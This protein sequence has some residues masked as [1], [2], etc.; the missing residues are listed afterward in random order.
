MGLNVTVN[1]VLNGNLVN[2]VLRFDGADAVIGFA[3]EVTDA[4]STIYRNQF[5]NRLAT[6]YQ[7]VSCTVYDSDAPPGAPGLEVIPTG[8]GWAGSN[9][10]SPLPNQNALLV[11]FLCAGGPPYRGRSYLAGLAS[12]QIGQNGVFIPD[13]GAAAA[14]WAFAI[15]TLVGSGLGDIYQVIES[16]GSQTVPK[17]TRAAVTDATPNVNPATQRRR[18]QGVG[19]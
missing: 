14:G 18:R 19:S 17:G 11:K 13:V 12:A 6:E 10:A 7:F 2:N 16:T 9:A 4:I 3:P 15:R 5:Q 1:Q 8:G